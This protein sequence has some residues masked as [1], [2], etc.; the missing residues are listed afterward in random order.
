MLAARV[1]DTYL[2]RIGDRTWRGRASNECLKRISTDLRKKAS[3]AMAVAVFEIRGTVQSDAPLF[4][5]GRRS[6]FSNKHPWAAPISERSSK[7]HAP[8]GPAE[9]ALRTVLGGAAWMHDLGKALA[10]FQ[11]RIR[12]AVSGGPGGSGVHKSDPVR[13]EIFSLYFLEALVEDASSQTVSG[14]TSEAEILAAI[15][16]MVDPDTVPSTER[17][18]AMAEKAQLASRGLFYRSADSVGG[19]ILASDSPLRLDP[20]TVLGYMALLILTHHRLPMTDHREGNFKGAPYVW[21]E[22]RRSARPAE[23]FFQV[24]DAGEAPW[25]QESWRR[26]SANAFRACADIDPSDLPDIAIYGRPA[27]L[28]ADHLGSMKKEASPEEEWK[29]KPLANTTKDEDGKVIPADLLLRHTERVASETRAGARLMMKDVEGF[30]ALYDVDIP[31]RLREPSASGRFQWQSDAAA[32][33]SR[34]CLRHPGGFFA[35]ILSGTGTGKTIGAPTILTAASTSD[36]I[37]SRRGLR[38]NLALGLRTLARQSGSEYIDDLGFSMRDVMVAV[39]GE[40]LEVPDEKSGAEEEGDSGSE[41]RTL[42]TDIAE[43][44]P[45]EGRHVE[46]AFMRDLAF[47]IEADLPATAQ[48]MTN[49]DRLKGSKLY[50]FLKAPALV[51]TIDHLMPCADAR[52][53]GH[54]DAQLRAASSDLIIDEV[55]LFEPEDI[56]AVSRLVHLTAAYGRRVIV[57][58]ATLTPYLARVLFSAYREGWRL[59]ASSRGISSDIVS[60]VCAEGGVKDGELS[61]AA[62]CEIAKFEELFEHVRSSLVKRLDASEPRRRGRIVDLIPG[63]GM[64]GV[65]RSIDM[66]WERLHRDHALSDRHGKYSFGLVRLTRISHVQKVSTGLEELVVSGE[67]Q[68]SGEPVKRRLVVL[69][70]EMPAGHRLMIERILKDILKRKGGDPNA[71][72]REFLIREGLLSE[73]EPSNVSILVVSSPVIETGND[74]DFDFAIIDP[75]STRAIVQTAGRV[76]RHRLLSVHEPNIHILGRYLVEMLARGRFENP[77]F[78]TDVSGTG[79]APLVYTG[80]RAMGPLGISENIDVIDARLVIETER[81]IQLGKLEAERLAG[82]LEG[83]WPAVSD[84]TGSVKQKLS[85]AFGNRRRFRRT[86]RIDGSIIPNVDGDQIVNWRLFQGQRDRGRVPVKCVNG[87]DF[88]LLKSSPVE[89]VKAYRGKNLASKVDAPEFRLMGTDESPVIIH[90]ALGLL[91]KES[92][93]GG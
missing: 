11:E 54:L 37:E 63:E 92:F 45:A 51:A 84:F 49:A 28:Y 43:I 50:D 38:F 55:D 66:S 7:I 42:L 62:I 93:E 67:R 65:I 57:M 2:W 22:A 16:D 75:S 23:K 85:A 64:K 80:D 69:H 14:R 29:K 3:K 61:C 20:S 41:E 58:S 9:C 71:R 77:G 47:D 24:A 30:P 68:W 60:L 25:V 83:S 72:V 59:Y 82:F 32:E 13:H 1:L 76:N 17:M 70:S 18:R 27:M 4:V 35:A 6:A 26:K 12:A 74:V 15:A 91:R 78:D 31:D 86:T 73:G 53:G 89:I 34:V 56:A 21:P 88:Y 90:D 8:A 5:V 48:A 10:M 33:V 39:G 44:E 40:N 36:A 79:V 46:T 87:S 81:E 52:R 19:E